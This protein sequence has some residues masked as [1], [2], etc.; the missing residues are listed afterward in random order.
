MKSQSRILSYAVISLG[1][2][3]LFSCQK[4]NAFIEE[5][6]TRT[7]FENVHEALIPYFE[8]YEQEARLRGVV[9]DLDA[10]GITGTIEDIEGANIAGQCSYSSHRPNHVTI[11]VNFWNR[12][13]DR[14]REFV[15]FHELGH[16][17][18]LRGHREDVFVNLGTCV[19]I[20]R[21]G[22][23]NCIDNYH[24]QTRELYLDEL[25]FPDDFQ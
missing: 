18:L 9:V 13:S 20:M 17:D 7:R 23:G 4:D 10:K 16:C 2:V 19:S 6:E 5:E 25:F 8:R 21:S 15:V 24:T 14:L 3:F 1:L 11:D 12:Y 22:T